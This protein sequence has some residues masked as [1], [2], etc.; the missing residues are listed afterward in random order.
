MTSRCAAYD[1][2]PRHRTDASCPEASSLP[3]PLPECTLKP[4][5]GFR[6]ATKDRVIGV[7]QRVAIFFDEEQERECC[8]GVVTIGKEVYGH[9]QVEYEVDLTVIPEPIEHV[10]ICAGQVALPDKEGTEEEEG[11]VDQDRGLC[12]HQRR[13]RRSG[14]GTTAQIVV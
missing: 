6:S 10:L 9:V 3:L 11:V 14:K 8:E 2:E 1:A 7:K 12:E 5:D 4:L 13:R